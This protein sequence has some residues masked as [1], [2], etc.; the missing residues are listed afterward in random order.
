MY[1]LII[2][3]FLLSQ[4][5]T[6]FAT[7][8]R[9]D[10]L[11][12]VLDKT[13]KEKSLYAEK[14]ERRIDSLKLWMNS[15]ADM[16]Q[17][18]HIYQ[19]LY[20]EY[21]G[22]NMNSALSVAEKN[23]MIAAELQNQQLINASEMNI[24]E[25]LG[26]MGMYKESLDRI[27]KIDRQQL[28]RQQLTHYFHLYHSLYALMSENS[29]SPKEKNHYAQLISQYK[30]SLLQTIHSNTLDYNVVKS[31]KLVEQERYDEALFLMN[32]NYKSIEPTSLY[33]GSF[34]YELSN[35][36]AK[37][38]DTEQEKQYLII[39]SIADLKHAAKDYIALRKLA[40][41]LYQEGDI[42][43]AYNYIKYSMEDAAF[44]GARFRMMEIAET[45]PIINAAYDKKVAEEKEK[46]F[47]YLMLISVLTLV[48]VISLFFIWRQMKKLSLAKKSMKDLY[49]G[50]KQMNNDLEELNKKL[51]ESNHVKEEYIGSVFNLCSTYINKMESY[52][53]NI[54]RK[55][56]SNQI[57]EARKATGS[58][59]IGDEFKEFFCNFDAI[60]L[61]IYPNFIEEFNSLLIEGEQIIPKTGNILTP[62][63]RVFALIR[64]GITDSGKIATFLHYSPQTV[65]NYKL[66]I[67]NKL[68]LSADEFAVAIQQIG[69]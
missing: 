11:L 12:L 61:S 13:I 9:S 33:L 68:S 35:I 17:R 67:R 23:R 47:K 62:E 25:L 24:S 54:N 30:D 48:L 37:K 55:L 16:E 51:S 50:L 53:I 19:K 28:D 43:R 29:L 7:N 49:E 22:Y 39:A 26:I 69:K 64:L 20:E 34:A 4:G 27:D 45:L 2:L 6:V 8:K 10:S 59:L 15:E 40:V 65:Y 60:F 14:K 63:L 38:G 5:F 1:K 56:V 31:G 57:E 58:T 44:C 42:N 21:R 41:L 36:Y 52:R 32:Q 46:L 66:K 3:F 18:Y